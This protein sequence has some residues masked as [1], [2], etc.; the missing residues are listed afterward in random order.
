MTATNKEIA[1]QMKKVAQELE[2][3]FKMAQGDEFLTSI[4]LEQVHR[5]LLSGAADLI[6]Q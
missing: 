6:D 1:N 2:I 3:L 4:D 5:E